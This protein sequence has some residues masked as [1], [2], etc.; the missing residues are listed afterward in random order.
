MGQSLELKFNSGYPTNEVE[1]QSGSF[2][3][4]RGWSR[5]VWRLSHRA[6]LVTARI[7]NGA[8]CGTNP[9]IDLSTSFAAIGHGSHSLPSATTWQL[10]SGRGAVLVTPRGSRPAKRVNGVQAIE[11]MA[12]ISSPLLFYSNC[13]IKRS[14]SGRSR[15]AWCKSRRAGREPKVDASR[16]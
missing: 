1:T 14:C 3:A 8:I 16:G 15:V 2:D 7:K 10:P 4:R 11:L 6:G 9:Q 13:L 5:V 12:R